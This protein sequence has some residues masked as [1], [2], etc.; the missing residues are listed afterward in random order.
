[1]ET[2]PA[3]AIGRAADFPD[4]GGDKLYL[5]AHIRPNR[6]LPNIGFYALMAG[7][8]A[9]SFTAGIAFI[10]IGAWPVFG[11]FGLDVL[12]V[13][14]CF[15]LNYRDGKRLEIVQV[16]ER[17]IRVLRRGPSGLTSLYTL[18]A[19]WTRVDL[20]NEDEPDSQLCLTAM[21]KTLIIGSW[22]S[23]HERAELAGVVRDALDKARTFAPQETGG[24]I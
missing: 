7:L 12:L 8:I 18:P 1:M 5:D 13:W 16:S 4:S 24:A 3:D 20:H 9:I 2:W 23:G 22:L 17:D 19:G 10:L 15:R 14:I 21:G 6:S 11:F